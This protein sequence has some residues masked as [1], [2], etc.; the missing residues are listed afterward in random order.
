MPSGFYVFERTEDDKD[1]RS[2]MYLD[3]MHSYPNTSG[4]LFL[5]QVVDCHACKILQGKPVM[6]QFVP[7]GME[8]LCILSA[9]KSTLLNKRSELITKCRHK[10]VLC[11]Q[12]EAGTLHTPSLSQFKFYSNRRLRHSLMTTSIMHETQETVLQ[13]LS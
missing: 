3:R 6:L 12:S 13:F 7:D 10:Q 2:Q 4:T 9:D 11:S 8:K 5:N 1:L